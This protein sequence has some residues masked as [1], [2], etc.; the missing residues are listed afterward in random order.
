MLVP[1]N[2]GFSYWKWSFWGY[3]HLRKH[4]NQ[5]NQWVFP[6]FS[7]FFCNKKCSALEEYVYHSSKKTG[8]C[9]LCI[10]KA[11]LVFLF[12]YRHVSREQNVLPWKTLRLVKQTGQLFIPRLVLKCFGVWTM[13]FLP[14]SNP[15]W[16]PYAH[17]FSNHQLQLRIHSLNVN[18]WGEKLWEKTWF[19]SCCDVSFGNIFVPCISVFTRR[20]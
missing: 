9:F 3:H 15:S 2:H 11:I 18:D 19:W 12:H 16:L 10:Q 5:R 1:N 8:C 14:I 7:Y 17:S 6:Y 13:C 4:P 20:R